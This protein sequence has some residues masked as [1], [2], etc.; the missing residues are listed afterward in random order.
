L[1][2]KNFNRR[3]TLT[4]ILTV[5]LGFLT[6]NVN[7]TI[8]V[9]VL[10]ETAEEIHNDMMSKNV[11]DTQYLKGIAEIGG[12]IINTDIALTDK[13]KQDG[14]SIRNNMQENEGMIFVFKEPKQQS[15]WMKGMKFPIDIIWLDANL[16][17]VHIEKSLHPCESFISCPSYRPSSNA[18]FVLETVSGFADS[19]DLKIGKKINFKLL[20]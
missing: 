11:S 6:Y 12:F 16:S 10:S 17:I 7:E 13:Q 18:L 20:E 3:L 8:F 19:H 4:I 2:I 1:K 14:L 9:Y 5:L 15:F